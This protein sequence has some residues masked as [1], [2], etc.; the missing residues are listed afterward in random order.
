[1]LVNCATQRRKV[2]P[3]AVAAEDDRQLATQALN[4]ASVAP[5]L[6][7]FESSK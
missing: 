5:T 1:M 4:A 2:L 7:P 3:L 6:V